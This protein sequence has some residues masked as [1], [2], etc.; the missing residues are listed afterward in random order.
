MPR[1]RPALLRCFV[2][3]A[4]REDRSA[5]T[6]RLHFR[7]LKPLLGRM[8][9]RAFRI[10]EIPHN[11]NI[12]NRIQREIENADLVV[13][14]LTYARPSVYFEAGYAEALGKPV[15][16]TCRSDHFRRESEH[17]VH[18]DVR[19]RNIIDWSDPGSARF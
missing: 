5:D 3:M 11:E 16:Y 1:T 4:I 14:D 12:D 19:Q 8:Q 9:I 6:N 2:A 18:F 17:Q 13:A 15:I 10:D 7:A